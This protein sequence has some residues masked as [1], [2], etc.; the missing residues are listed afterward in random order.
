MDIYAE[1]DMR[2]AERAARRMARI[3]RERRIEGIVRQIKRV[4]EFIL[5]AI[6]LYAFLFAGALWASM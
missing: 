1:I 5:S 3:E 4:G 2:R 6:I